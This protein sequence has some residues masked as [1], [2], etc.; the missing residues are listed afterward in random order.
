MHINPRK[1]VKSTRVKCGFCKTEMSST[2]LRRHIK[3][4]HPGRK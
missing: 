1:K 3:N 4:Q 2:S